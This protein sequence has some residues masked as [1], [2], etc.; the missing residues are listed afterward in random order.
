MPHDIE[1]E[2]EALLA[3]E[4][5]SGASTESFEDKRS[6]SHASGR[7]RNNKILR[8]DSGGRLSWLS[9]LCTRNVVVCTQLILI[10][11]FAGLWLS[12]RSYNRTIFNYYPQ[13]I[14]CTSYFSF[15]LVY[16]T[17]TLLLWAPI[18]TLA[19]SFL[20]HFM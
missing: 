17:Y 2:A 4:A 10:L 20:S 3:E 15:F 19:F 18:P 7:V 9:Y 1:Y 13:K 5:T 16:I 8:G 6:S 14:Y 12:E 11:L